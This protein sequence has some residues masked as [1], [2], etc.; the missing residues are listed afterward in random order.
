MAS[1]RVIDFQLTDENGRHIM[2]TGGMAQICVAGS[3]D[4]VSVFDINQ[5]AMANPVNLSRGRLYAQVA[6]SVQ[7]VDIYLASPTGQFVV[8]KGLKPGD[9]QHV[10]V[11]T[12]QLESD[13]II[14]WSIADSV[15]AVEKDSGFD[16]PTGALVQ[17]NPSIEVTAI[18][19]TEDIECG[20][21]STEPSGDL[22]GFINNVSIATAGVVRAALL[23][24]AVTLGALLT[25]QDSANAGDLVPKA[26]VVLSTSRSIAYMLSAGSD[27]GKG[28]I[29]LA[30]RL[31][32]VSNIASQ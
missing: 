5:V 8:I 7:S 14:P 22:D 20:I 12:K 31:G 1:N 23:N 6:K 30:V 32:N 13:W 27:T 16:L 24:G 26:H 17:G 15:Q 4:K 3:P 2:T 19:A 28:F 9:R 18:D 21:L 11:D 25:E 29:V 10:L